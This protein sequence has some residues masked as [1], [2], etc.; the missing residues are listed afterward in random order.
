MEKRCSLC[1]KTVRELAEQELKEQ[2]YSMNSINISIDD[3]LGYP[4][5]LCDG[6]KDFLLLVVPE[7]LEKQGVIKFN[8]KK[9]KYELAH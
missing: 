7:I 5:S 1:G 8:E 3:E 2:S 4:Y 9:D 6:C